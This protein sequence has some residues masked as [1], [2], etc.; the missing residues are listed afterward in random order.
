MNSGA[1]G[2]H[3]VERGFFFL[4]LQGKKG[5]DI[6]PAIQLGRENQLWLAIPPRPR[7]KRW[8]FFSLSLTLTK[9]KKKKI[10]VLFSRLSAR[11]SKHLPAAS[12]KAKKYQEE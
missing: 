4:I 10:K 12:R 11:S 2:W 8:I 5:K 6:S 9:A 3:Y 1:K 7:P